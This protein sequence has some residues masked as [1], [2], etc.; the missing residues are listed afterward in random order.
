MNFN[1]VLPQSEHEM[2]CECKNILFNISVGNPVTFV[3]DL[4]FARTSNIKFGFG[5]DILV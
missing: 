5:V 3:C 2:G 1:Y 4:I